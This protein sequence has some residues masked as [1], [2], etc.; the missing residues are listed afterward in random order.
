MPKYAKLAS[1]S[2]LRKQLPSDPLGV[3]PSWEVWGGFRRPLGTESREAFR[4]RLG[5]ESREAFRRRL[6]TLAVTK[7]DSEGKQGKFGGDREERRDGG[8]EG[9]GEKV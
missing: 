6:G 8:G 3:A 7:L 2:R 5:T 4:R 1:F 9:K